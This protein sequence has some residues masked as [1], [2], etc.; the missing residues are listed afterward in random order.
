MEEALA[1]IN[2]STTGT[3]YAINGWTVVDG[4]FQKYSVETG[5]YIR[6]HFFGVDERL[7]ESDG[8]ERRI[9]ALGTGLGHRKAEVDG[10]WGGRA[11]I[12][13]GDSSIRALNIR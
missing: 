8:G 10:A 6:K 1:H 3:N 5:D 2:D 11:R 12:G 7:P 13:A 4:Q 9:D